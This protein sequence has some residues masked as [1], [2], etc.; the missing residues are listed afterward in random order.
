MKTWLAVQNTILAVLGNAIEKMT[1]K[2]I[3]RM[4]TGCTIRYASQFGI[5]FAIVAR[6]DKKVRMKA[7]LAIQIAYLA[8]LEGFHIVLITSERIRWSLTGCAIRHAIQ[9]LIKL[10]IVA[11]S[12]SMIG[13]KT[14]LTV[15]IAILTMLDG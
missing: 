2:R 1:S 15:H 9:F 8:I 4:L 5:P 10:A 6:G 13:M 11:S 7:W 12:K 14:R 3:W